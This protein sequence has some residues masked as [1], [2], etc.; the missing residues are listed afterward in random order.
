MSRTDWTIADYIEELICLWEVDHV[1][2]VMRKIIV[3]K[4][5]MLSRFSLEELET[6]GLTLAH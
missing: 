1:P 4:T 3:I 6:N 2:E 5:E